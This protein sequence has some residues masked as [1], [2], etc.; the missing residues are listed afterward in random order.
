MRPID[1]WKEEHGKTPCSGLH[2]TF[3]PWD[4]E[5]GHSW[6]RTIAELEAKQICGG[7][8]ALVPC[9]ES[10]VLV[11]AGQRYAE[12]GIWAGRNQVERCGALGIPPVPGTGSKH[13][14]RVAHATR[15]KLGGHL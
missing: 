11:I 5:V 15:R 3:F 6:A 10:A 4:G 7:C 13:A 1:K 2:T 14:N 12:P 9:S 8:P